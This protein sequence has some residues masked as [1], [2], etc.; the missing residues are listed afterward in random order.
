MAAKPIPDGYPA[1]T[2]YIIVRNGAQA[3]DF[4]KRALGATERMRLTA[5]DGKIGH[6]EIDIGGSVVMLADEHPEMD[7]LGPKTVG[8]TPVSLHVYVDDV[9]ARFK[10][11]IAAGAKQ[12]RP[13]ADMFY[14]DRSGTLEDPYGHIWHLATHK[15]DLTP[16]EINKRAATMYKK[17]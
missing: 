3:L 16:D 4:Y 10:Q 9:D 12:K 6:A 14:G 1:V 11:A 17:G 8:G 7:A 5:P 15:E 13:I 2:P